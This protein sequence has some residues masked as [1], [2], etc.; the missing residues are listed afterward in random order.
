MPND[1]SGWPEPEMASP[2]EERSYQIDMIK[3]GIRFFIFTS[4][5]YAF[6]LWVV[7]IMLVRSNIIDGSI[8]WTNSA[9]IAFLA[10]FVRVWDRTFLK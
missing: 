9:I 5:L 4:V 1:F 8:S 10:T 7:S 2:E 3:T 6:L